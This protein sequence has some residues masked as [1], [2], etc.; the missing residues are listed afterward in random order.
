MADAGWL[1]GISLSAWSTLGWLPH[2][3]NPSTSSCAPSKPRRSRRG[4][5]AR[6]IA[7]ATDGLTPDPNIPKL[8]ETQ[9]E[10]TTPMWDYLDA[11]ITDGRIV[12]RQGGDRR[13]TGRCSGSAGKPDRRRSLHPRRHLGRRDRLWRGARQCQADPADHPLAGDAGVPEARGRLEGR[14]GLHRGAAAGPARAARC[15]STLV[16]LMGRRD[17]ASAG[18][19]AQ[20]HRST[21]PT[22]MATAGSISTTRCPTRWRRARN[23]SLDLGYAPGVDWGFEVEVPDGF[24]W[25]LADRETLRPISFFAERGVTRVKG[26]EFADTSTPVFLYAP[27]G[28]DGPKFLMTQQLPRAQGLQFLGQLRAVRGAS[29]GPA[30]RSGEFVTA[31]PAARRS[32]I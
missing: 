16:G 7:S 12:A 14:A 29:C 28:Q 25:L 17:R 11:R 23:S 20:R 31:W 26:T 21:A 19:S 24:D 4:C 8:V 1:P 22:A 9:P 13:A 32:P 6:S 30:R 3:P 5:V 27:A 18:Q 2:A 10:F 15:A